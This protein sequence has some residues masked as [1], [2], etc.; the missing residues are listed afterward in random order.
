VKG[1][2]VQGDA[3]DIERLWDVHDVAAYTG[4]HYGTCYR[5]AKEG[6]L[7]SLWFGPRR[8]RFDPIEVRRWARTHRREERATSA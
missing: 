2:S 6:D 8:V 7:P 4:M 3:V 5:L 1:E